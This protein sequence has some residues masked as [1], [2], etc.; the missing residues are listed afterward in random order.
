MSVLTLIYCSGFVIVITSSLAAVLPLSR[1]LVA[2]LVFPVLTAL[3]WLPF[4]KD[5]WCVRRPRRKG[6][7]NPTTI[8]SHHASPIQLKRQD[9]LHFWPHR[10]FGGRGGRHGLVFGRALQPLP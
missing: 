4:M 6:G 10:L 9:R 7:I 1:A 2:L 8:S 5:L 3:S